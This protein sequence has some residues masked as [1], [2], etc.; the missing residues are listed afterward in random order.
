VAAMANAL[1]AA[2]MSPV[3]HDRVG[4]SE[5]SARVFGVL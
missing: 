4:M 3:N 2:D 1:T 5:L